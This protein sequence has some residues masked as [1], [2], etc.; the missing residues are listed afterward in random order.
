MGEIKSVEPQCQQTMTLS[1][2]FSQC[3]FK[4]GLSPTS[5]SV[6]EVSVPARHDAGP[7]HTSSGCEGDPERLSKVWAHTVS[8]GIPEDNTRPG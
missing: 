4:A 6:C 2:L 3:A 1:K 8:T 5:V 7:H